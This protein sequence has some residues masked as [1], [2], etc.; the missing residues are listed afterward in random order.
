MKLLRFILLVVCLSGVTGMRLYA[1]LTGDCVFL[2][3]AFV[4]VG[5]AP[6]GGFGSTLPAPSGYHPNL[7]ASI[8]FWDPGAGTMTSS[9]N[10]LGFVADFGR[11]G[12][13]TG[14]PPFFGDYYL[15]G[16]P[17]EGWAIEVNG[18]RSTAYIPRYQFSGASGYS[19]TLTGTNTGYSSGSGISKGVWT[20]AQ[21]ALAIRQTTT[22]DTSK[23]YFTVNVVLT[24]TGT[25]ALTNIYYFRTVDPDNEQ[26]RTG[27][28]NTNN[29]ITYQLPNPG[30][31]VLVSAVGTGAFAS[32]AYLGL[33]TKD[34][35]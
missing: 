6:N 29:T 13:T 1:Q 33:G 30:S 4:E 27:S 14:T 7:S 17:Q 20:G 2:Q 19:G 25:T 24:N 26:T 28:F 10:F 5:V 12:W 8:N 21:G 23:L 11:D 31:K 32:N 9:T 35:R 15:P 22:L 3:G 16:S 18:V 34:C